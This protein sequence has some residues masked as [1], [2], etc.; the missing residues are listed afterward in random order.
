MDQLIPVI[1]TRYRFVLRHFIRTGAQNSI[2]VCYRYVAFYRINFFILSQ[3]QWIFRY[4]KDDRIEKHR[5]G[6]TDLKGLLRE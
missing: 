5:K 6:E 4:I 2:Y 3:S 1:D